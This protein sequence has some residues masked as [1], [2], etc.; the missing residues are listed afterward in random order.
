MPRS[1]L[2]RRTVL[3]AGTVAA[4]ST[5]TTLAPACAAHAAHAAHAATV[6]PPEGGGKEKVLI[7]GIDGL[8][9]DRIDDAEAPHLKRLMREGTYGRSLL[10]SPPMAETASGPGWSTISTGVWPDKHGV[11]DNGFA[12]KDYGTY[13]T[14]MTRLERERPELSTFAAVDW[15]PLDT[16]GTW[17][18]DADDKLVLPVHN[19]ENDAKIAD[20]SVALLRERN[21]D[22]MFVYF[23][24]VDQVGHDSGTGAE[25]LEAI[26]GADTHLG[27]LLAAVEERPAYG[28]ENWLVLVTTDHGHVDAGGHGGSS[29]AERGTFVLARGAGLAAGARPGHTLLVDVAP[30]VFAHLGITVGDDWGLDGT[31]LQDLAEDAFDGLAPQLSTREDE[32]GIP[33]GVRGFTHTTPSGW[34]IIND[35]MGTD[36]VAEWRGWSF[37]TDAFWSAAE[38]DQWR[39]LNVRSRGVFAVADSDEWSDKSRSGTF[40]S[41]L[42]TPAYDVRGA[43]AVTLG[44]TTLYR[45]T[46]PDTGNQKARVLASFNA[47][48]PTVVKEYTADVLSRPQEVRVPVPDGASSV[49]FRFHYCGD[50]DWYWCVDGVGVT[51]DA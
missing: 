5:A 45:R 25:Y 40:D 36:G 27:G 38:R 8:R 28:E 43:S 41:T 6:D 24:N 12:G 18:E 42:V 15:T 51:T 31:A 9:H 7:V 29:M 50:N 32:T 49:S 2:P 17:T 20:A 35:A 14:L 34:S 30:T 16:E 4:V 3:A 11:R 33:A 23:G 48:E 13:P 26:A 21:P 10:Y 46:G 19:P 39:E 47:G 37:T 1:D 44:Y 22:V